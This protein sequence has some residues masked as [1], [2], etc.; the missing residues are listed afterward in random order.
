MFCHV[1]FNSFAN[2]VL[3]LKT[4]FPLL[5]HSIFYIYI[6]NIYYINRYTVYVRYVYVLYTV[7]DDEITIYKFKRYISFSKLYN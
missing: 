7:K 4:T 6:I 3:Y 2:I 5:F 1:L